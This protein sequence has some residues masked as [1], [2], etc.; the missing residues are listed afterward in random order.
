M[1]TDQLFG[2]PDEFEEGLVHLVDMLELA[3]PRRAET[4]VNQTK[5]EGSGIDV[6]VG[7][8]FEE[9]KGF[10]LDVTK[11]LRATSHKIKH[12]EGQ[13]GIDAAIDRIEMMV[14]DVEG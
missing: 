8:S 1:V 4:R 6:P 7:G 9:W 3:D 11:R 12:P 14:L 13:A 5:V 2:N 10:C